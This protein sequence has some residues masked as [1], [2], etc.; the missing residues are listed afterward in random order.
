MRRKAAIRVMVV[1]A[2]LLAL[3]FF[4]LFF[5]IPGRVLLGVAHIQLK[6]V[7][8]LYFT[9]HEELLAACRVVYENRGVYRHHPSIHPPAD[10]GSYPDPRDP[11]MPAIIRHLGCTY[12]FLDDRSLTVE[13]GGGFHHY[14]FIAYPEGEEGDGPRKLLDGLYYYEDT[15]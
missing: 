3:L 10:D 12:I 6:K 11:G 9:N 4:M 5:T 15:E 7:Q 1:G 13:M 2:F 14:G 8:I